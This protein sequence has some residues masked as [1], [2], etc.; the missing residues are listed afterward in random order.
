[1]TVGTRGIA[2]AG[3]EDSVL[4][5]YDAASQDKRTATFRYN[6]ANLLSSAAA[7][8][9]RRTE[10]NASET[11]TRAAELFVLFYDVPLLDSTRY[12]CPRD[13]SEVKVKLARDFSHITKMCV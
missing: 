7:P 1:V 13:I 11:S 3:N 8:C 12:F 4:L 2:R 5:E 9:A 6:V 10:S